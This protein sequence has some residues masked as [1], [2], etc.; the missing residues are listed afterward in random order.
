MESRP[1]LWLVDDNPEIGIIVRMLCRR[2]GQAF[3][4][5]NAVAPAREALRTVEAPPD[6]LLLD[7]NLP[8][9][10]G[11][12]LLRLRRQTGGG[13]PVA[14]FCQPGL[15]MDI[16]AG[17]AEGADYLLSKD[18]VADPPAWARRVGEILAHAVGGNGR[19]SLE[20]MVKGRLAT[21]LSWGRIL[22]QEIEHP[23]LRPLGGAVLTQVVRRCLAAGFGADAADCLHPVSGR[24]SAVALARPASIGQARLVLAS[25]V[26][27]VER[28]TGRQTALECERRLLAAWARTEPR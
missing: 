4:R 12:E 2:G 7:V 9:E 1:R 8:G 23:S 10:S 14:L 28:L 18:L 19:R 16:A 6:L 27:Q 5:F 26:D 21:Q 11:L 20:W 25:L 24:V 3:S 15:H 22:S 17:W 13:P